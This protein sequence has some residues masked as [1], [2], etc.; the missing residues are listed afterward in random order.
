MNPSSV[1]ELDSGLRSL[2]DG[3]A[4]DNVVQFQV[5]LLQLVLDVDVAARAAL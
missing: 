4:D 3:D 5:V 2:R 1:E